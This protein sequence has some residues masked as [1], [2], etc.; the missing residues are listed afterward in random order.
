MS[1]TMEVIS[2]VPQR[3]V[4]GPLI[5]LILLED[6]DSNIDYSKV[7]SFADDTRTLH[8]IE[9]LQ[10]LSKLQ[11]DLNSIYDWTELNNMQLYDDKFELL[12]YGKDAILKDLTHYFSP[13]GS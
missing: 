9:N 7:R 2:G 4:L 3:S 13:S 12:R 5:F 11:V 6:I 8:S 10:D 1:H